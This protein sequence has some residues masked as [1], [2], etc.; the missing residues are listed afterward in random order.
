MDRHDWLARELPNLHNYAMLL[1]E[2]ATDDRVPVAGKNPCYAA[3]KYLVESE[4]VIPDSDTFGLVDDLFVIF[5]GLNELLRQGGREA[6]A[7]FGQR[8]W[9][10]GLTLQQKIQEARARFPTFWAYMETEVARGFQ[11]VARQIRKEP[12]HV[13][14][15]LTTLAHFVGYCQQCPIHAFFTKEELDQ[16]LAHRQPRKRGEEA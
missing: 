9:A 5:Y 10:D 15:L 14:D 4:D 12:E 6:L 13:N 11:E 8:A 7:A 16:F 3:A 1:Y 2:A